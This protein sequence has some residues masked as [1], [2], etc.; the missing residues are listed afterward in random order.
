[1][2]SY[3]VLYLQY[4]NPGAYPPLINSAH[5]FAKRGARVAVLGTRAVGAQ[6]LTF[7]PHGRIGVHI[8]PYVVA[9]W[10]QKIHFALY[11]FWV[12]M[13][14]LLWRPSLI[15]ASDPLSAPAAFLGK[16]FCSAKL[17]YHEHDSP[18]PVPASLPMSA[19][20]R[21]RDAV[22][23]IADIV[24][25]PNERRATL[26]ATSCS[27]GPERVHVVWNCPLAAEAEHDRASAGALDDFWLLFHGSIS[28]DLLPF[29]ILEA[30]VGLPHMVK[31]RVIGYETIGSLGY[32][33]RFLER[34]KSLGLTDRVEFLGS[35]PRSELPTWGRKSDVGLV[36]LPNKSN[37]VNLQ[38]LVGAS[39]K[40]FDYLA[41]GC[42]LLVPETAEW[43]TTFVQPGY[44]VSCDPGDALSIAS[45]LR[46]LL[47][48]PNRGRELGRAGQARIRSEWNYETQFDPILR[49]LN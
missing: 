45:S 16:M 11:I 9:G 21:L 46:H 36:L 44:A 15:Y 37:N 17:I 38:H 48:L 32:V 34:A 7:T 35:M 39:N 33:A 25:V 4:S 14:A 10:T 8:M 29:S 49:R 23:R 2:R 47:A 18:S 31:L 24:V 12:A 3:K 13:W 20:S 5:I 30:M 40:A 1:M 28:T 19:V 22:A 6:Q 26:L 42:A 27:I 41:A 43:R